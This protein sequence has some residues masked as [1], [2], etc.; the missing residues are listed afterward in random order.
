MV[1]QYLSPHGRLSRRQYFFST[2]VVVAITYACVFASVVSAG[3]S[4]QRVDAT[5]AFGAIITVFG[6]GAQVL[7]SI[8]RL[9][10][11]GRPA[12]HAWLLLV[13]FYGFY[14]CLILS[15]APGASGDNAYGP[16][17]LTA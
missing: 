13:P 15:F 6:V 5:G 2:M 8:R 11:I 12:W 16:D 7:L 17:P 4:G 3:V 1:A 14:L 9:H 10:D